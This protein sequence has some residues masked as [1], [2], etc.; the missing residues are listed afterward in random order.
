MI[1]KEL[2]E[3]SV[4]E[5]KTKEKGLKVVVGIYIGILTFMSACSVYLTIQQGFNVFTIL[6][7]AFLP[8]FI[9]FLGNLKKVK[10][11]IALRNS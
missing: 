6:P 5:L 8:I 1:P 7:V 9:G 10:N 4:E 11:E 2:S 3:L